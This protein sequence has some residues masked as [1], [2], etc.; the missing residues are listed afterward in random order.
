MVSVRVCSERSGSPVENAKV[1][2]YFD[3]GLFSGGF[4][5][6]QFTDRRG[7]AHFDSDPGPGRIYVNG[8]SQGDRMLEGLMVVYIH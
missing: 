8:K 3:R 6:A 1:A 7:E 4:T 2:L 5:G